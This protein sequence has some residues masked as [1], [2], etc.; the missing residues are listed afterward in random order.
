MTNRAKLEFAARLVEEV[1]EDEGVSPSPFMHLLAVKCGLQAAQAFTVDPPP[2]GEP[3]R[4][5]PEGYPFHE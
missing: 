2:A 1:I 4:Q 5:L 3:E